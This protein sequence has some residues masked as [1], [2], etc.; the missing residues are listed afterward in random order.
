MNQGADSAL[1]INLNINNSEKERYGPL[2]SDFFYQI[3]LN[4]H[5][6]LLLIIVVFHYIIM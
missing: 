6:G 4:K 3:I 1:Y 2:I 5:N